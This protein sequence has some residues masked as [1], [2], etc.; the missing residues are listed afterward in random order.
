ML[1]IVYVQVQQLIQHGTHE[2]TLDQV[3]QLQAREI[4]QL[5]IQ[6]LETTKQVCIAL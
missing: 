4:E 3:V 5:N 2:N 6:L 1:Y